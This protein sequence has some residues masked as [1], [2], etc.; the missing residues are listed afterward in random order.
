MQGKGYKERAMLIYDG[1]HYDALALEM[2][3]G[4][5][6]DFDITIFA[7]DDKGDVGHVAQLA[8]DSMF[9]LFSI[10]FPFVLLICL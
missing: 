3:P 7:V 1:L 8:G 6:K 5:P 9:P 4:A 2:F 10:P